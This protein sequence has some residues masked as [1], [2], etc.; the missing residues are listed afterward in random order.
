MNAGYLV[1]G[2]VIIL[3]GG[4]QIWLRHG[5]GSEDLKKAQRERRERAQEATGRAESPTRNRAWEG[6]TAI[7]GFVGVGLGIVLIILGV[8]NR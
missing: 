1:L 3:M 7:L 6:W 5:P 8:L 4:A 2:I